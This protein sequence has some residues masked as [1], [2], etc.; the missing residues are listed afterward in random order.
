MLHSTKFIIL[1]YT[2]HIT[3][4]AI[5]DPLRVTK[6]NVMSVGNIYNFYIFVKGY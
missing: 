2:D 6:V 1:F 4:I 5:L 3:Q